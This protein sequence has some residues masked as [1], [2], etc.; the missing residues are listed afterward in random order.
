L[1]A[2]RQPA[3]TRLNSKVRFTLWEPA[4]SWVK[5][6]WAIDARE[7][8]GLNSVA[9]WPEE[10]IHF[11]PTLTMNSLQANVGFLHHGDWI[12]PPEAGRILGA[13]VV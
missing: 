3:T 8:I 4:H 9:Q 7:M 5:S 6:E 13:T 11:L 2:N 1:F 12:A 10:S